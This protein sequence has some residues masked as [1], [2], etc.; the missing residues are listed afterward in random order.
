MTDDL[1]E[2]R[3]KKAAAQPGRV[4]PH[5]LS[6]EESVIGGCLMGHL[7][8]RAVLDAR[9]HVRPEDFYAAKH[10][11]IWDAIEW[12]SDHGSHAD[13]ITVAQRL[14]TVGLL[15]ECG[16]EIGLVQLQAGGAMG[17]A[18]ANHAAIVAELAERRRTIAA[19]TEVVTQ[20][21]DGGEID[22][23]AIALAKPKPPVPFSVIPVWQSVAEPGPEPRP[24][25]EG[26][27]R[28][29][30]IVGVAAPRSIGK[31]WFSMQLA[32]DIAMGNGRFLGTFPVNTPG[33]VLYC[34]YETDSRGA[35]KRWAP[36]FGQG[37]MPA[38][39]LQTF[40]RP[41][42]QIVQIEKRRGEEKR[43]E[44]RA[45]LAGGLEEWIEI[46]RPDVVICDPWA[47]FFRG[48][49][50]SNDQVQAAFS[51]LRPL[52]ERTGVAIVLVHHI[53]GLKQAPGRILEPEDLWRGA[54]SLADAVAVRITITPH[55]T[56]ASAKKAGLDAQAARRY[57]DVSFKTRNDREPPNMS[58][59]RDPE[60]GRWMEWTPN[61]EAGDGPMRG[62]GEDRQQRRL[63]LQRAL[64]TGGGAFPS[65]RAAADT[66]EVSRN[67]MSRAITE[68]M[69]DGVLR[70]AFSDV[71]GHRRK[72]FVAV[73][74]E[75]EPS[76]WRP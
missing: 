21:Y 49:S 6:A 58:M 71:D 55:Y 13:P 15:D 43:V 29:G 40:S 70:E 52:A 57:V 27:F 5:N 60:N 25:V 14:R 9:T 72:R 39:L 3:R 46:E 22:Y 76:W 63:A 34:H 74:V 47:A 48:E 41:T 32:R 68:A 66:A 44:W 75:G 51:V 31:T 42:L 24:I 67:T 50:N 61:D 45:E 69:A 23:G 53:S 2:R 16:G 54:T 8:P 1:T 26:L 20:A 7:A 73:D 12:V 56:P 28:A 59:V 11:E 35:A 19:L 33:K 18:V 10:Q 30:E 65:I 4:S 64:R 62:G 38:H 37:A 36:L 17:I